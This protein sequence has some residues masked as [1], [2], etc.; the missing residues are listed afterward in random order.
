MNINDFINVLW[1][2]NMLWEE[3][4]EKLLYS[5][6]PEILKSCS[7]T[8][9]YYN[10]YFLILLLNLSPSQINKIVFHFHERQFYLFITAIFRNLYWLSTFFQPDIKL[11]SLLLPVFELHLIPKNLFPLILR[12]FGHEIVYQSYSVNR[13]GK[14]YQKM[15]RPFPCTMCF[16]T[17]F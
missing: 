17:S 13:K 3:G 12:T 1:G 11:R 9:D 2:C 10:L 15:L 14:K 4:K 5:P 7:L 16:Y 6:F 8:F